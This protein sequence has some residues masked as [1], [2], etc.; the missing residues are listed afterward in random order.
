M[1]PTAYGYKVWW[2]SFF[3]KMDLSN[4]TS[5][6]YMY[7]KYDYVTIRN[8]LWFGKKYLNDTYKPGYF[9]MHFKDL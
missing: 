1:I 6:M 8:L 5:L 4:V 9:E 3:K 2:F 7:S